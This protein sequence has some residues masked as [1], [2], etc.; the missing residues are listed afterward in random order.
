MAVL[1]LA[2]VVFLRDPGAYQIPG[3][4]SRG[5]SL[6]SCRSSDAPVADP[7][8]PHGLFILNPPT[9]S[10]EPYY[11]DTLQYLQNNS[12]LCGADFWIHWNTVDQGPTAARQYNWT[13]VDQ[14]IL[15]WTEAGKEVNLIMQMVGYGPNE[16][17]V[18]PYV[19]T[20]VPTMQCANSST[21]PL[22]WNTTVLTNYQNFM[23]ATVEHFTGIPGIG[24]IRFGLGTGGETF[25][26]FDVS[27]PGC[28]AA[29][30]SSGFTDPLWTNYLTQMLDFEKALDAPFQ[31]MVA[32]NGVG[33][34]TDDNLPAQTA[35]TAA[36]NGIGFGTEGFELAN[37]QENATGQPTPCG[38]WCKQFDEYEGQV[39]LELQTDAV[40]SPNGSPPIGSLT[41]LLPYGLSQHTQIFELYF[42]DC[43]TAYDP[44]YPGYASAHAAYSQVF[45]ETALTVG[46]AS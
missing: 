13:A 6:A 23:R 10:G 15:P 31:L 4:G 32:L 16:T 35:A 40:S 20:H 17:Y 46:F 42:E 9:R 7:S 1:I 2:A 38:G 21:T 34:G 41:T 27:A 28:W 36:A 12:V 5:T 3:G 19:L 39:P 26:L 18:P 44:N 43:L 8:A 37:V 24:Y 14:E 11:A 22:F 29:L 25:P 45:N 33:V 30:N